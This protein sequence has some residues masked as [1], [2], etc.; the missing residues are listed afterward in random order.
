MPT[1]A[2]APRLMDSGNLLNG[3]RPSITVRPRESE[4]ERDEQREVVPFDRD[5]PRCSRYP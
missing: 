3:Y 4:F 2:S 5:E 1:A